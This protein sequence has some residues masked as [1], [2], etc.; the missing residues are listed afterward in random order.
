MNR[1]E[2]LAAILLLLQENEY[3]SEDIAR[4]FEVSRRTVLRDVQALSEMGVPV[5]ARQGPGGGYSL[6]EDY[7]TRPLPLSRN[8]AFLLLL[9]LSSLKELAGLPFHTEMVSLESKLG[10][11]LPQDPMSQARRLLSSMSPHETQSLQPAHYLEALLEAAQNEEWVRV[12]YRSSQRTTTQHLLPLNIY[13]QDGLWYLLAFAHERH[14]NRTYRVDRIQSLALAAEDFHP[15]PRPP[16]LPYDH[17]SH[18]QVVA[19]LTRRGADL[20]ERERHLRR[21]L[22]RLPDGSAELIFRC[23]PDE[24]DYYTRFFASL[25][26]EVYVRAPDEL[27]QR[28]AEFGQFFKDTYLKR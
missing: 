17:P 2:R 8:E 9:A 12:V 21:Q 16:A 20:V 22:Q 7:H 19:R 3:T 23:P 4:H 13:T 24:L 18:P 26:R 25:G 5:I 6:P 11:L 27:R 10:A 28:L 1:I 14:Q 15:S